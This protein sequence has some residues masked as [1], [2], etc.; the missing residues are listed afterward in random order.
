MKRF[1]YFA[2]GAFALLC[3]VSFFL[4]VCWIGACLGFSADDTLMIFVG[5]VGVSGAC[6]ILGEAIVGLW[7]ESGD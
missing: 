1:G 6:F 7:S 3:I 5:C 2:V 4:F